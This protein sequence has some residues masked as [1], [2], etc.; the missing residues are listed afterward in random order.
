MNDE[1]GAGV[2]EILAEL[3]LAAAAGDYA[4]AYV[5]RLEATGPDVGAAQIRLD[6]ALHE[7]LV[8]AGQPCGCDDGTCPSG[9]TLKRYVD[10]EVAG[11]RL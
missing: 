7:L 4:A 6:W 1:P 10:V 11:D 9:Y 8:A 2:D 3:E 5:A